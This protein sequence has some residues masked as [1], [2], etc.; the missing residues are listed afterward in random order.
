VDMRAMNRAVDT[1]R[2]DPADVVRAFLAQRQ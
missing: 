2:R 1:E